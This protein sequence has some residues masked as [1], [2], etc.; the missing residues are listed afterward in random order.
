MA[1][2]KAPKWTGD[3]ERYKKMLLIWLRTIEDNSATDSDIVSAVILGLDKATGDASR[4]CELILDIE[5]DTLYPDLATIA[6]VATEVQ[7]QARENAI[8][9][10]FK[11]QMDNH[12]EKKVTVGKTEKI[13][14]GLNAIL[15]AL[16]DKFGM[17]KE[18]KIFRDYEEY[19]NLK[20]DK[21][22]SMKDYIIKAESLN[23]KLSRHQIVIPDIVLAYNLLK[24]ANLGKEEKLARTSV[25]SMTFES[26]KKTLIKMSDGIME[27]GSGD[28]IVVPKIKIKAEPIMYQE[29]EDYYEDD[30]PDSDWDG[31]PDEEQ[32]DEMVYYQGKGYSKYRPHYNESRGIRSHFSHRRGSFR[33]RSR[34]NSRGNHR[35]QQ[36]RGRNSYDAAQSQHVPERRLNRYGS[37]CAICKSI[38]HWAA[39]C[40]D[41]N[42]Q[43]TPILK[44]DHELVIDDEHLVYNAF[45]D[46]KNL[47]IIDSGAAKTVCGQK[48]Y[49]VYESSLMNEEKDLIKEEESKCTFRFGDGAIVK[50]EIAKIFPT[51]ICGQ[52]VY[53]KANIVENDIPLLISKM[54]LKNAK[55]SLNFDSDQLV[56]D[57]K[58]QDLI[59]L[60]SNHYAIAAYETKYFIGDSVYYKTGDKHWKGPGTVIGQHKKLVLVKTGGSFVRVYPNRL[61]LKTDADKMLNEGHQI[62]IEQDAGEESEEED[63]FVFDRY[64][65]PDVETSEKE[66]DSSSEEEED[67]RHD[68]QTSQRQQ[69]IEDVSN[70]EQ[71][72]ES[73]PISQQSPETASQ[74]T[75]GNIDTGK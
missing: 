23:R 65:K 22:E 74:T 53:I 55:A 34:A 59:T 6:G 61:I 51:K 57:G 30:S 10:Y 16:H 15:V 18:E 40:P 47:G 32:Q 27:I 20:R 9:D 8:K 52:D 69:N 24:G 45:S 75:H 2:L 48:W 67:N 33:G 62:S 39:E 58:V 72:P 50:S 21:S 4:A 38:Y 44:V 42:K 31:T 46:T 43:P 28:S 7:G 73:E 3:Y 13:I 1:K 14:P 36:T 71:R 70:S 64:K 54:T 17:K 63:T 19:A 68:V 5:E 37:T 60:P 11:N 12:P 29:E 41:K 26:M 35:N 49:K 25:D 66:S 56:M